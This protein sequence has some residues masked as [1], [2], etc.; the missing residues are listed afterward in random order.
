MFKNQRRKEPV[1][2][3]Y[4]SASVGVCFLE[5]KGT[6]GPFTEEPSRKEGEESAE[7]FRLPSWADTAK[8]NGMGCCWSSKW[9]L[10]KEFS[11]VDTCGNVLRRYSLR[12]EKKTTACASSKHLLHSELHT[13][14]IFFLN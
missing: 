13:R 12:P 9:G 5:G 6:A 4:R 1:K 7:R 8:L 3:C 2:L 10:E 11:E 14:L